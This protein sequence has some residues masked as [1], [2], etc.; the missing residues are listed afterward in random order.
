MRFNEN[1][2][3][4]CAW[5]YPNK[6]L[7]EVKEIKEPIVIEIKAIY[8]DSKLDETEETLNNI[9]SNEVLFSVDGKIIPDGFLDE[10]LNKPISLL[11]RFKRI[12]RW[13]K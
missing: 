9:E 2:L 5:N 11:G 10:I 6:K 13:T 12:I 4:M 3:K 8:D 7:P 1:G